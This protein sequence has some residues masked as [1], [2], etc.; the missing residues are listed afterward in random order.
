MVPK[1]EKDLGLRQEAQSKGHGET[2]LK[3]LEAKT[4]GKL[5]WEGA[6]HHGPR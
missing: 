2:K 5:G 3:I 4:G 6:P 1:K